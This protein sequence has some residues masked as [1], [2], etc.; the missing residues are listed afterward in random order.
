MAQAPNASCALPSE[1][2]GI[3]AAFYAAVTG[4][5]DKNRD[6]MKALLRPE[7]R[8]MFVPLGT[9]GAP[10]YRIETLDDWTARVN[11]RGHAILEEK[12]LSDFAAMNGIYAEY[13]SRPFPV[14]TTI[15]VA[16]LPLG[17]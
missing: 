4:P 14:R 12:Q 16:A 6:C 13:F 15:E 3:P 5:A 2:E 9:D 17:A 11:A 10:T 7:A 1:P 8:L